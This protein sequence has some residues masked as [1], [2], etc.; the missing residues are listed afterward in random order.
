[1]GAAGLTSWTL[2]GKLGIF[3]RKEE[4]EISTLVAYCADSLRLR[5]GR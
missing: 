3:G 2:S 1:M 5:A 4:L